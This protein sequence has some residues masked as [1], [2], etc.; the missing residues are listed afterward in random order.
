VILAA[1]P[2][3]VLNHR[4]ELT[5]WLGNFKR[6]SRGDSRGMWIE[7]HGAR[8]LIVDRKASGALR[9]PR[10]AI[11]ILGGIQPDR[12]RNVLLG[13][14]DDG[15]PSRFLWF[16]PD[17]VPVRRPR[18]FASSDFIAGS[19]SR[20]SGLNGE[21]DANTEL[22]PRNLELVSDAS[23]AFQT[24]REQHFESQRAVSGMLKSAWGKMPGL[25]L[26]LLLVLELAAGQLRA[27]KN[28]TK[29]L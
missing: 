18:T 16:W 22:R 21:I 28:Q 25:V 14:D 9:I 4:D 3:G 24:W 2:K 5:G 10:M 8:P 27:R 13:A 20:L 1:N 12:L 11:S 7:A 29:C 6:Y 17:A 23:D 26:R 15:L 19:F